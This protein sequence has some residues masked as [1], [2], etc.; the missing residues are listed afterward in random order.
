MR[1]IT[2]IRRDRLRQLIAEVADGNQARFAAMI[3]KSR[4]YVGFWLTDP[5]KP[6]AK[7][8]GHDAAREVEA[9]M[10]RRGW[11]QYVPGWLDTDPSSHSTGL[12]VAM[13]GVALT[14]MDRVIRGKGLQM[15]GQ[16]GKFAPLLKFAYEAARIEF[17]D[18]P[19][20]PGTRAGKSRLKEFDRKVGAWLE[21]GIEDGSIGPFEPVVVGSEAGTGGST[22]KGKATAPGRKRAGA[23]AGAAEGART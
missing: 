16:L 1:P 11:K 6:H 18:G 8:M 14:S 15:E 22:A 10:R 17:P 23:R 3:D 4:A 20:S 9:E 12:D 19:P 5:A 2:E 13:L 21:G 7:A